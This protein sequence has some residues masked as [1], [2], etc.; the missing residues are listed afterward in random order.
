MIYLTCD[1]YRKIDNRFITTITKKNK[2]EEVN[3]LLKTYKKLQT[4]MFH[5]YFVEYVFV[6][7]KSNTTHIFL[8]SSQA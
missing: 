6:L 7:N 1:I 3:S 4:F 8:Y 2:K 5:S